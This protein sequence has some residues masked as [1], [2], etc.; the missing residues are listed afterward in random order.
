MEVFLHTSLDDLLVAI[1]YFHAWRK[2]DGT[3]IENGVQACKV[4]HKM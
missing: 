4:V 3:D 1:Q 2:I